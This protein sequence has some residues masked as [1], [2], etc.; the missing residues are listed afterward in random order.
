MN[1]QLIG[2]DKRRIIIGLGKTGVACARYLAARQ[3]PFSVVDSRESPPGLDAFRQEFPDVTVI[4]GSFDAELLACADEL[5]V[6]PG[7]S[8]KEAAI[9]AAIAVGV[10]VVGDI[11]LFCRDAAAPVIAITG[12]N[13]KSTVTTLVGLMAE[14]AGIN[15]GVGGNIGVPVLELLENG[16]KSLYVLE[17]SSFQLETTYSLRAQVA[18]M[19]NLTPDHMDRYSSV[20][21]YHQAKQVIYRGCQ[22]AVYNRDDALSYP[23][24]PD[25]V[26]QIAFTLKEPDLNQFGLRHEQGQTWL[27]HGFECLMPVSE[28]RIRGRHNHANALAAL[29]IG[30][31][32]GFPLPA[33]LEVLRT[34][35][36]LAHRCQWVSEKDG[37][38]WF[39]DSKA[40]NTGAAIAAIEGLG[41]DIEGKLVLIAGGDGKGADFSELCDPVNQYVKAVIAIGADGP[42]LAECLNGSTTLYAAE[43]MYDAVTMAGE[44]AEAGDAVLLAPACASFDMFRSFEERGEVFAHL[45]EAAHG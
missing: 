16:G 26:P 8:L 11:E 44:I 13:G 33:M 43:S 32:A 3:L 19:L 39:N 14:A 22:S 15:V 24:V 25:S 29:A 30:H 28:I 40:T 12:S 31:Q 10:E 18:V 2:S 34:F 41:A 36:G 45:V 21:D 7:V 17:L 23:L 4:T 1:G 37:V 27:A 9:A 20:A 35:P 38:S 5:I 42:R 6:S